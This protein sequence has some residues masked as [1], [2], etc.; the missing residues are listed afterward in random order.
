MRSSRVFSSRRGYAL[1]ST[2]V[3]G[4]LSTALLLSLSSFLVSVSQSESARRHKAEMRYAA[5]AAIEYALGDISSEGST[6]DAGPG[7]LSRTTV[8]PTSLLSGIASGASN[9]AVLNQMS[10]SVTVRAMSKDEMLAFAQWSPLYSAALSPD[11]PTS[12]AYDKSGILGNYTEWR[13]IEAKASMGGVNRVIRVVAEP[14]FELTNDMSST[15]S[16]KNK[17]FNYGAFGVEGLD[18]NGVDKVSWLGSNP[19]KP[20]SGGTNSF[21]LSIASNGQIVLGGNAIIQGNVSQLN[22]QPFS[23]DPNAWIYGQLTT[24]SDF[25]SGVTTGKGFP[26]SDLQSDSGSGRF[27]DGSAFPPSSRDNVIAGSEGL[28]TISNGDATLDPTA[29]STRTLSPELVNPNIQAASL[30]PSPSGSDAQILPQL[31]VVAQSGGQFLSNSGNWKTGSLS[32]DSLSSGSSINVSDALVP[33]DSSVPNRIFIDDSGTNF[34][35]SAAQS[36]PWPTCSP[37][38]PQANA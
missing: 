18:L 17:Y 38:C 19:V 14:I 6:L 28:V 15:S 27:Y 32:T 37:A 22:T 36:A 8:V 2:L 31:D 9:S 29:S 35:D 23:M 26:G 3:V 34:G 33:S 11:N 7:Q 20:D 10:V 21:Q 25:K 4:L 30:P 13:V 12:I 24:G 1:V 16:G 5:E